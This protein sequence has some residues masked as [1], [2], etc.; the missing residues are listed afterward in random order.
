VF[1]ARVVRPDQQVLALLE[2]AWISACGSAKFGPVRTDGH[3]RGDPALEDLSYAKL[4]QTRL[5]VETLDLGSEDRERLVKRR[6]DGSDG[7]CASE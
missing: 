3:S 6:L 7:R 2:I 5:A 1:P 4:S